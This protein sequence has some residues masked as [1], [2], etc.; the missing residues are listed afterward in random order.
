MKRLIGFMVIITLPLLTAVHVLV[1]LACVPFI[2]V[3]CALHQFVKCTKELLD[4][5]NTAQF[6]KGVANQA[7]K[8]MGGK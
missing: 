7:F 5:R 4:L 1:M 8:L 6:A 3:Y 2:A